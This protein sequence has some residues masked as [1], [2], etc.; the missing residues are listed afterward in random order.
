MDDVGRNGN[1]EEAIDPVCAPPRRP[2]RKLLAFAYPHPIVLPSPLQKPSIPR[3]AHSL[4]HCHGSQ[5]TDRRCQVIVDRPFSPILPPPA[6]R[7]RTHC[8][9][10]ISLDRQSTEGLHFLLHHLLLPAILPYL[11][12]F[13]PANA[14]PSPTSSLDR[15]TLLLCYVVDTIYRLSATPSD[16]RATINARLHLPRPSIHL[17]SD[18]R[19]SRISASLRP[20]YTQATDTACRPTQS[21]PPPY[22]RCTIA[23]TSGPPTATRVFGRTLLRIDRRMKRR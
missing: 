17:S 11:P 14:H 6:Y 13:R 10:S 21:L 16:Y 19:R 8:R 9:I 5:A 1:L 22:H 12:V 20:L 18:P 23:P 2:A 4:D 15:P 3:A 7:P